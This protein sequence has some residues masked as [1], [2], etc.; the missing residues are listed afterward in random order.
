M[1]PAAPRLHPRCHVI[2]DVPGLLLRRGSTCLR[3]TDSVRTERLMTLLALLDGRSAEA[4]VSEFGLHSLCESIQILEQLD[5]AGMLVEHDNGAAPWSP[6]LPTLDPLPSV[7]VAVAEV[8]VTAEH[9]ALELARAGALVTEKDARLRI[10]CPDG[11]NLAMLEDFNERAQKQHERWM[12]AFRLGDDL[13]AGPI[14]EPNRP[15]CFRCYVLRWLGLAQSIQSERAYFRWLR[16]GGW[17]KETLSPAESVILIRLAIGRVSG[18]VSGAIEPECV[19]FLNLQTGEK[20]ASRLSPHPDCNVCAGTWSK[21]SLSAIWTGWQSANPGSP[22]EQLARRLESVVDDRIGLVGRIE[23]V[24]P[25]AAGGVSLVTKVGQFAL[26]R[27]EKLQSDGINVCGGLQANEGLARL[28]AIVEGLERYCGLFPFSPDIIAAYQDV[29]GQALLPTALPLFSEAQYEQLGFPFHRFRPDEPLSWVWGYSLTRGLPQLVPRSAVTYGPTD[30]KL[31]DESSSGIAAGSS[32]V[33]AALRG[34]LEMVERDA[35]M[36]FWLNRLSPP[37]LDWGSL[38]EGFTRSAVVE[39]QSA[40]YETFAV[41]VTTDLGIPVFLG[42][43]MRKDGNYPALVLGAG[44]AFNPQQ[45]LDK[46]WSE[47]LGAVRWSLVDPAWSLK[48]PMLPEQVNCLDDHHTA[49]SHPA[50]LP[51]AEFLW[52]STRYQRFDKLA[53]PECPGERPGDQLANAVEVLRHHEMEVIAVDL[54]TPDVAPTGL[55]VIRAVVPGLQPIGF[56]KHAAR[57]G[58][59][60]LYRAPCRMGYR[61]TPLEEQELNTVPHCFP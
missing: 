51:R 18:W 49:Y 40:G 55:R 54:T 48:S 6:P 56:G 28:V 26:P 25:Q 14:V 60:R 53:A 9:L 11:A 20:T 35:F 10:V 47:T 4:A 22:I 52:S 1:I 19:S 34:L 37:L 7:A 50:W 31:L 8:G 39:I 61:A 17:K 38:P 43:A 46:A 16:E 58:G 33:E 36:I 44:C 27:V 45:A 30:D 41:N 29:C 42:I 23:T 24:P 12:P 21:Q 13:I 3:V 57:L 2:P 32:P 15:G 5:E 59:E